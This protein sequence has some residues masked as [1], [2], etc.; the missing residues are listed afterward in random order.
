MA[1]TPMCTIAYVGEGEQYDAVVD[2]AMEA[3]TGAEA[4]LIIYDADAGARFGSPL[5]TLT[6]SGSQI[7]RE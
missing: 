6:L 1:T 5:P 3:A 2:A 7:S 4:R